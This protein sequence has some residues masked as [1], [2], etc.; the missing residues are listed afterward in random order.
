[1]KIAGV[2][3]WIIGVVLLAVGG[4]LLVKEKLFLLSAQQATAIVT[5]NDRYTQES[6]EYGTQHYYCSDF[7]FQ[8]KDGR[9]I[10]FAESEGGNANQADCGDLDAPPDYQLGQKVPVSYDA[11]DPANSAQ[12]PKA[13]SLNYDGGVIVLVFAF[14]CVVIGLVLFWI[15][16][17]RGRRAT[18]YQR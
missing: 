1:M 3:L 11:R 10:S 4:Y 18:A 17:V 16:L 2:I 13:I 8:T 15:G 12:I 7:Q 6:N 5:G 14:I 9:S